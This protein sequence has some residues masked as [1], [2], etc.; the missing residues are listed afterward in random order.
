[1]KSVRVLIL[2]AALGA[3]L[4]PHTFTG[5]FAQSPSAGSTAAAAAGPFD[6][7][8]FRPIG[9]A[10]MSGRIADL[11][12]YEPNPAIFYVGTAHGGVWKTTNS[13]TTFEPQFQDQGLISIGDVTVSQSNP[14]LVWV[15]TGESNNRQSTSWGDGVYKSTD[16][17]KTWTHM[18]LP[19]SRY[20]NRIVIDPRNNDVV[21]VAATG[22]LWGPGGERGIFK[23][24]DGGRTWKQVL[25]IDDDTGANDLVMDATNNRI[26]YAS[27]YQRR[28]TPCCM[29]GGGPGSGIWKTTD[30]G[31]TWTR[32]KGNGLPDGPL[33]R[34][35][36][37][38]NR[39]RPNILYALVEGP[40]P[41]AGRGGTP[42]EAPQGGGRGAETSTTVTPNTAT[43]LY[44]SD[45]AGA[46]WKKVN[47]ENPRP[48]YFS[49]VRV[50]PN[51]PDVIIYGGVKLHYST[52]GGR[53]VTLN[54]T[55]TIH[56]DVH[57]I[58]IDPANSQHVIIGNDGGVAVSWDQTRTWN[59]IP[60]LPV[61]LFY[62]VSVDNQTPFNVCGGMQD[63]YVWCG[64]SQVRGSAG[65]AGFHWA[66]MQ[67][68]D[69]FVALQDPN[70]FR[71]AYSESQ[72]GNMVRIDRVTGE[73]VS[74]RPV[75]PSS[76]QAY[77]WNWDTPFIL[78]PHNPSILFAGS[79]RVFRSSNHGQTWEAV[80]GDL[81]TNAN[82]DEIVTMGVKGSDI[83]I[84]KND[85][86]VA[87][88]TI[89]S[90]AESPKRPNL[91]YVGTDDGNVQV[92]R[93]GKQWVNVTANIPNLPNGLWV[94]EV[95]PSR[96]D[97]GTVYATFDGHR[98]N[99]YET[100]I[101]VS[102]DFGQTWQSANGNLKGQVVKTITEDQKNPDVLYIGT[103]TGLFVSTD[104]A[105]TWLRVKANLPTV[106]IDEI[107]LHPR[108][109][110]MVLATHGRALWVLDHI[111]P[112][113]EYAAA[114]AAA[115]DA[116]LFTP[117]PYAM[118]RRPARDRNYEFWGDQ[119]F[120][121]ENPPA[122]AVI[123]W[124]NKK[125]VGDVKLKITDAVGKEV[126]EI[127]GPLLAK[128]TGAGIQTACW[129]L[130]V[131]PA[132]ALPPPAGR[133][134][135]GRGSASSPPG[136][137]TSPQSTTAEDQTLSPA[138][139]RQAA[140]PAATAQNQE[141]SP[142][143][144]GCG[145][146]GGFGGGGFGGFGATVNGPFVLS[147]AYKV[148]LV[149]DGKTVDTKPL[150][151]TDDPDVALTAVDKKRM[152]DQ[153]MEVH[154][155]QARVTD[156]ATAYRS[157]AQQVNDVAAAVASRSDVAAEVKSSLDALK[158]DLDALAPK[159]AIPQGG[160]GGGGRGN[161]PE[162]LLAKIGQAKNGLM[163][164]M[165][166]G[167]QTTTAYADA[168][169]EAPKAIADLNAAIAKAAPLAS[170][171][172]IYNL[173]LNVPPPVQAPASAGGRKSTNGPRG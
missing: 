164:G 79:N 126:R 120:Y 106:R 78:S 147:G 83:T 60:N 53:T 170:S 137:A 96:F 146:P 161:A 54:A 135:G 80:G 139:G 14:D 111:E 166:P 49:Q 23:T 131:Q 4:T 157:L 140:E 123:T 47:D 24:T 26:L 171:L 50:D 64:P 48:M 124:I 39:R 32:L 52:D 122:A 42:D 9:P 67:G 40:V 77:R 6:T 19:T 145:A 117:P 119:T 130:R 16:G 33:G 154:T 11:A 69:G 121:G 58:W 75:A 30:G 25:K 167:E 136:S 168:R 20:I 160:R 73:T 15:G 116:R 88:G 94:S 92:S 143:G 84:A 101:Y 17:G 103:E 21:F 99:D 151:V 97:E 118:Y 162:S 95:A 68:G 90:L 41:S 66:T 98:S 159:L 148:S 173:T 38:V 82:R 152:F 1:M 100:Y 134:R 91:L 12:V 55:R 63:N 108:D 43:G 70:D 51:D 35:G 102:R 150:R 59:F 37:D 86:I 113:Q 169:T 156:A 72:D 56:D 155:L 22:S 8:H 71:T 28:R 62:H 34:I 31:E 85:G 44:R 141:Q 138:G 163:A 76:E 57:A 7:L 104:R 127:S 93:E 18:G 149:V 45:D 142:F 74:M 144:A 13:G 133:G 46:T 65:I 115:T 158:K 114:Q 165:T 112:F 132:P 27:S 110:S 109:N 107:T 81:T 89:I 87:W 172:K 10:S 36:L 29:N 129:D 5:L 128:S 61:G 3:A 105:K 2:L 153:A 125:S